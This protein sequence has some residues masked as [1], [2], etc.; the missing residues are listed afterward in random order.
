[1][2]VG[3]ADFLEGALFRREGNRLAFAHMLHWVAEPRARELPTATRYTYAPLTVRQSWLLF[4]TAMLPSLA[5]LVAG[6]VAWWQRRR[7]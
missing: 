6:G 5:F 1:M 7:G 3:D 2:V 4:S